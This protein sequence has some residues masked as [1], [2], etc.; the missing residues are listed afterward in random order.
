MCVFG[1]VCVCCFLAALGSFGF[2]IL[3][4]G[5]EAEF[6]SALGGGGDEDLGAA[7]VDAEAQRAAL[8]ATAVLLSRAAHVPLLLRKQGL[9]GERG[10]RTAGV[11]DEPVPSSRRKFVSD[12]LFYLL[13]VVPIVTLRIFHILTRI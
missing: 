8:L 10:L 1:Y 6:A 3:V 4:V 13:R 5:H 11:G 12:E 2:S 7:R 9:G